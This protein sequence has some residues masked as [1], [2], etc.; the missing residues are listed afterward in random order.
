MK[1]ILILLSIIFSSLVLAKDYSFNLETI[2]SLYSTFSS[3]N[4][5]SSEFQESA[6]LKIAG[7]TKITDYNDKTKSVTLRLEDEFLEL[8]DKNSVFIINSHPFKTFLLK[9]D[10]AKNKKLETNQDIRTDLR[11][12]VIAATTEDNRNIVIAKLISLKA[13]YPTNKKKNLVLMHEKSLDQTHLEQRDTKE[14]ELISSNDKEQIF[15]NLTASF[16]KL[17]EKDFKGYF[18]TLDPIISNYVSNKDKAI[19]LIEESMQGI[20]ITQFNIDIPVRAFIDD[21]HIVCIIPY[22]LN[23]DMLEGDTTFKYVSSDYIMARKLRNSEAW[24]IS[25]M[26]GYLKNSTQ[27]W[28]MFPDFPTDLNLPTTYIVADDEE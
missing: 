12:K 10:S 5:G 2:Q 17:M 4:L 13:Y 25:S 7:V 14:F 20:T 18:E 26:N 28:K 1:F 9:S 3:E 19:N 16:N 21:Y 8:D 11:L 24:K 27:F 6:Y 15:T 22:S 23:M